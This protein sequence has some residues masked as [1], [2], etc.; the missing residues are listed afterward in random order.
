MRNLMMLRLWRSSAMFTALGA[1]F[2]VSAC[3]NAESNEAPDGESAAEERSDTR[4]VPAGTSM[5]FSVDEQVST[6]T[7]TRGDAF[8]ATLRSSVAYSGGGGQITEGTQSRWI[9]REASTEGDQTLLAVELES[10]PVDGT[11]IPVVG[12]VTQADINTDRGDTDTETGAKIAIGTAVGALIGQVVWSD[13]RSTLI[14]AGA[15]AAVGTAVALSARGG[16]AVLPAGS[17]ITVQLTEPLVVSD[18]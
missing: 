18:E 8:S 4:A 3:S 1:L 11:R 14:G 12:H 10:I 7:H 9:V 6:E 2:A 15:G 13:T 17:S 5:T 16:K